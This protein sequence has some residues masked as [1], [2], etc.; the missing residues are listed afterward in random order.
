MSDG[1][2]AITSFEVLD[3]PTNLLFQYMVTINYYLC[4]VW[5]WLIWMKYEVFKRE[6]RPLIA[7]DTLAQFRDSFL[8]FNKQTELHSKI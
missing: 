6:I 3:I 4:G 1:D 7:L 2:D 5:C 8:I